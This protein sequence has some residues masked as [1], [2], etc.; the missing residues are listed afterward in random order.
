MK[1]I[2]FILL[3]LLCSM[4]SVVYSQMDTIYNRHP[5]YHYTSWCDSCIDL[6][7]PAF[8]NGPMHRESTFLEAVYQYTNE[9]LEIIG[10]AVSVNKVSYQRNW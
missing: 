5:S 2:I 8:L 10:V 3:G 7:N 9:P 1:K 4:Q 6:G